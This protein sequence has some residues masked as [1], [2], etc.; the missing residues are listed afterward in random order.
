MTLLVEAG[1]CSF[2]ASECFVAAT[3]HVSPC[4]CHSCPSVTYSVRPPGLALVWTSA[5]KITCCTPASGD[6][7]W[8]TLRFMRRALRPVQKAT[9]EVTLDAPAAVLTC[10]GGLLL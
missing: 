5:S 4:F 9:S 1:C 8:M 3:R 2:V 10:A 7:D 6:S